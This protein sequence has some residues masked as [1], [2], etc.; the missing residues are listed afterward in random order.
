MSESAPAGIGVLG[1]TGP[2]GRGLALRLAV[3]GL[4]L[5]LGSR[6]RARGTQIADALA[7]QLP[8]GA[9]EVTGGSN[10]EVLE[11]SRL[12][13][14][15]I[16]FEAMAATLA[17][18]RAETAGRVLV[19]TAVP[20]EFLAGVPH[21]VA[22]SQGSA[23]ELA[24]RLCPESSVVGGFHTVAAG[25]LLRLDQ[26][27]AEDVLLTGDDAAA[28]LLVA[29]LVG[30]IPGLRAIDAGPLGNAHFCEQ[31]TP[32]L[33]RLNRLHHAHTGVCITGL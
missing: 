6:D 32:F 11:H 19:S 3:S 9:G 4:D 7:G 21:P 8:A 24:A 13:L 1:G 29:D 25:Q 2:L 5:M 14:L 18:L 30:R 27:L 22:T 12:V 17:E 31:L 16:P 28:K 10:R 33:L 15:T 20:M 23:A 26:E